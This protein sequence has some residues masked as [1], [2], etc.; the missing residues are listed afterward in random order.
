MYNVFRRD[1]S[2]KVHDTA[3]VPKKCFYF[4]VTREAYICGCFCYVFQNQT[5]F[6]LEQQSNSLACAWLNLSYCY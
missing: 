6:V 1:H 2:S 5:F 3:A 4:E